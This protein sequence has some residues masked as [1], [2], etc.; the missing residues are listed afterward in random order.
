[1]H[2]T[3]KDICEAQQVVPRHR[4]LVLLSRAETSREAVK[5]CFQRQ[6]CMYPDRLLA[7]RV[8]MHP[9]NRSM[10]LSF[11]PFSV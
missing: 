8:T 10:Y 2:S 1:M 4:T 7:S 5:C 11:R 6:A 9:L 3:I